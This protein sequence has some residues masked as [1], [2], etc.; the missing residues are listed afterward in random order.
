MVVKE[1][2]RVENA[3]VLG[4]SRVAR[5]TLD[6]SALSDKLFSS[7]ITY[8]KEVKALTR[9]RGKPINTYRE[10]S[11]IRVCVSPN[12]RMASPFSPMYRLLSEV[13]MGGGNSFLLRN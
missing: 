3:I 10:L 9:P 12:K 5:F 11:I 4:V 1:I 6:H 13:V 8:V 7:S 2:I